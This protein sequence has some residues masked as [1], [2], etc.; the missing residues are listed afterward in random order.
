MKKIEGRPVRMAVVGIG[1]ASKPHAL[2]LK[3]LA[4][5][6]VEVAC[7]YSRDAAR[8]QAFAEANGWKA[9]GSLEAIAADP[10]VDAVLLL[11][12]PN[13]RVEAVRL[14]ASAG[15]QILMEKPVERTTKAAEEIVA[16]AE[17]A[18]IALGI[19]FQHRLRPASL[20]LKA[21][22]ES[23]RLGRIG[24][25]RLDV[26]W[27]RPQTYYDEPGRGTLARDGGG[28]LISQAIHALDLMLS[29]LGPVDEVQAMAGTTSLHRMETEDFAAAG[30]RFRSGASGSIVATTAAYPG[31]SETLAIHAERGTA[32]FRGG[33][34]SVSWRDGRVEEFGQKQATGGGAD[35]M[36]FDHGA[37][38]AVIEDFAASVAAGR[39][40]SITGRSALE[41][42]RLIDAILGSSRT[43]TRVRVV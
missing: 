16:I 29:L 28:V 35:P 19:V 17:G 4:D 20:S 9:A 34:L 1:M 18:K 14:F 32:I 30:V 11:T 27:W 3:D 12:P 40:S 13:A 2:A 24:L 42:H 23:G 22:L 31:D 41:V 36:A 8:R 26:P 25:V 7:V 15:K 33:S 21:L 6:R 37:H 10:A 38:R 5:G 39:A 43:G